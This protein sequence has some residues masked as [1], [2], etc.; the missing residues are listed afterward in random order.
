MLK[1]FSEL[2]VNAIFHFGDKPNR[3]L[4]KDSPTHY[5]SPEGRREIHPHVAVI[6]PVINLEIGGPTIYEMFKS[7]EGK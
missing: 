4:I 6:E 5:I 7:Q 1:L 3:L 2:V